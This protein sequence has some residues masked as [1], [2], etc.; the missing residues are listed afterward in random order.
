MC[1]VVIGEINY[2]SCPVTRNVLVATV[3]PLSTD[4]ST[5]V[6]V[7]IFFP[8]TDLFVILSFE[9]LVGCLWHWWK[10]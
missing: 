6:Q 1:C 5:A 7:Q 10:G 4:K 8:M 9:G 3:A 2:Q